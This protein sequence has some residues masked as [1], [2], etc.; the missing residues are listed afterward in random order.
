MKREWGAHKFTRPNDSKGVIA[1]SRN[2][3]PSFESRPPASV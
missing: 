2:F 3:L 1:P